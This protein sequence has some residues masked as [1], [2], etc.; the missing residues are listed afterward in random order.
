MEQ[1]KMFNDGKK[2]R[3]SKIRLKIYEYYLRPTQRE[4]PTEKTV[5]R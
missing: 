1:E 5:Q 3:K 4:D 2:V